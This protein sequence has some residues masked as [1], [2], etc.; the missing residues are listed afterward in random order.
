M[1]SKLIFSLLFNLG[2][3]I[4]ANEPDVQLVVWAKD[5]LQVSYALTEKP[6]VTFTETDLEI[7]TN[8]L[9]ISYPLETMERFTYEKETTSITDLNSEEA[10][11]FIFD[12]N[13]LIFPNL[14]ANG[15]VSIYSLNGAPVF[16]RT[17]FND[18]KYAF[19]ISTLKT[20]IYIINVNGLTY[21]IAKR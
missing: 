8:S 4:M 17:V 20:G 14:K 16:K 9:H 6:R 12:G 2:F 7:T 21:K 1:K 19:S 5:G 18:G 3:P 15:S 11:P 10:F 13:A